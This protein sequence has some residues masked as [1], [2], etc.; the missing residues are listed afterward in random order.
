MN[1]GPVIGI[2]AGSMDRFERYADAIR[3]S[4]G[5]P[6]AILSDHGL[7]ADET[8]GK[9][10]GLLMCGGGDIHPRWYDGATDASQSKEV[11][12]L[13]DAVEGPLLRAALE[14][15]T[16]VLAICRGM[17]ALNVA[18]GGTLL[19]DI[20]GHDSVYED[21]EWASSYHRVFI[22]P[23]SKLASIVG[24]GGFVRVNSRHHQGVK[25]AQKAPG[26]LASAYSL[27]DGVIEAVESADHDWVIGVQFHPERRRE[28]PPQF[29]RL[30][31]G[32]V[33]RAKG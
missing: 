24:A 27:E 1:D 17:Q 5:T 15:D 12:G 3:S 32:L 21:G 10:G 4:G 23:G 13:R 19:K 20:A 22:A 6:L 7:S 18:M 14:N 30:F 29:Q 26:L 28:V 25:E 2:C 16:P 9:V 8:L 33:E 11:G 31:Q